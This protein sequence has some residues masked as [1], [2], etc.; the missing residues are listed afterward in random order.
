MPSDD[1]LL[2][3]SFSIDHIARVLHVQYEKEEKKRADEMRAEKEEWFRLATEEKN[4]AD[5]WEKKAKEWSK[6]QAELII[7]QKQRN[8]ETTK[9]EKA[10][11]K[12]KQTADELERIESNIDDGLTELE[13]RHFGNEHGTVNCMI[14]RNM[15]IALKK[16]RLKVRDVE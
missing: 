9:A 13:N 8:S 4:R 7:T 5:E 14:I 2:K 15:V 1:E 10:K 6:A 12:L 11:A 16:L 3:T